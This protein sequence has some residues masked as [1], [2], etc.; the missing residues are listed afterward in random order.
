MSKLWSERVVVRSEADEES[1]V[2]L[3]VWC[4]ISLHFCLDSWR[5]WPLVAGPGQEISSG[6]KWRPPPCPK[7]TIVPTLQLPLHSS[8]LVHSG[9]IVI[10]GAVFHEISPRQWLVLIVSRNR[11]TLY[12][13]AL[14]VSSRD[15]QLFWK[16]ESGIGLLLSQLAVDFSGKLCLEEHVLGLLFQSLS[17]LLLIQHFFS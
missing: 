13:K 8:F 3:A 7:N 1:L 17:M 9:H 11:K 12:S 2:V 6:G 4:N 16:C 10:E 14:G 5:L 15:A